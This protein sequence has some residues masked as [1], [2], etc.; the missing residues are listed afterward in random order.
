MGA[1]TGLLVCADGDA[2]GMMRQVGAA[3]LERTTTMLRRLY[4]GCEIDGCEGLNLSDG[5]YPPK[6]TVYAAS[7]PGVEVVGDQSLMIDIPS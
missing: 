7:W 2:A 4:P 5:V 1:K 3:D 6:G